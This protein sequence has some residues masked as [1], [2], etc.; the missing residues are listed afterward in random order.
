MKFAGIATG[1]FKEKIFQELKAM[2]EGKYHNE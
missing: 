1:K 2:K